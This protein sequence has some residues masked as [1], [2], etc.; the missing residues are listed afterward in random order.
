MFPSAILR[1]YGGF[2][3]MS[4]FRS[5]FRPAHAAVLKTIPELSAR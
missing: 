5:G 2:D 1:E 3:L 4:R